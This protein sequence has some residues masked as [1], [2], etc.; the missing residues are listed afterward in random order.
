MRRN[1]CYALVYGTLAVLAGLATA[2]PAVARVFP[3]RDQAELIKDK[4]VLEK[5]NQT[6]R[7]IDQRFGKEVLIETFASVPAADVDRVKS[8]SKDTRKQYFFERARGLAKSNQVKGFYIFANKSPVTSLEVLEDRQTDRALPIETKVRDAMLAHFKEKD[9]EGGFLKGVT[10]IRDE[11]AANPAAAARNS[12]AAPALPGRGGAGGKPEVNWAGII[13]IGLA[14]ILVIWLVIGLIRGMSNRG[15]YAGAGAGGG[16]G[17]GGGF[18]SGLLGG[19]FGA[20]AGNWLYHNMFGGG[21]GWGS[22]AYGD[23][24]GTNAGDNDYTGAGGDWDNAGGGGGDAGGD[25]GGGG[26][27]WGGGGGGDWGGGGGGDW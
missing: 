8:M 10:I 7:E 15:G 26:G 18:M 24:G 16:G 22:Q 9:F 2:G 5:I 1:N 11:L 27:D 25:W 23:S 3:V 14:V 20:M 4:A 19:L 12:P 17:G 21:S 13:C 6:I